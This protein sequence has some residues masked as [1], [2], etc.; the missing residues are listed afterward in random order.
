MIRNVVCNEAVFIFDP[1]IQRDVNVQVIHCLQGNL[2]CAQ[3]NPH[4]VLIAKD[5]AKPLVDVMDGNV[6]A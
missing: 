6:N 5:K 1:F 4:V 3:Q 2:V